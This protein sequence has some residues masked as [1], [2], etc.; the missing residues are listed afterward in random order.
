MG[1]KYRVGI[2][3]AGNIAQ[4]AHLPAYAKMDDVEVVAIADWN[5]E[6]A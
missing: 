6:R 4:S 5:L 1:K 2:V 3:G